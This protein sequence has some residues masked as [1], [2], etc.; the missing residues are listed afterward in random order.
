[1]DIKKDEFIML[2][3]GLLRGDVSVEEF[4]DKFKIDKQVLERILKILKE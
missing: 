4:A 1:M 2:F 3:K